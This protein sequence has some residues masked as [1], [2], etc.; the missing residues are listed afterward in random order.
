VK[1]VTDIEQITETV[2]QAVTV[3][4]VTDEPMGGLIDQA[5]HVKSLGTLWCPYGAPGVPGP[6]APMCLPVESLE[7]V[8]AIGVYDRPFSLSQGDRPGGLRFCRV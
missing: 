7:K 6:C 1:F 5:V 3:A 2:V 4:V 8:V